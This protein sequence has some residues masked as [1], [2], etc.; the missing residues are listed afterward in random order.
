MKPDSNTPDVVGLHFLVPRSWH[1]RLKVVARENGQTMS[2]VVRL[3]LRSH[4]Y[5]KRDGDL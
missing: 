1:D 2:A 3:I 4:L 5:P